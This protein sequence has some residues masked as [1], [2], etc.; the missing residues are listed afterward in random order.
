MALKS[1]GPRLAVVFSIAGWMAADA[2]AVQVTLNLVQSQS[3]VTLN[4][5]FGGSALVPQ[6]DPTVSTPGTTDGDPTQPSNRTPL[7][8]TIVV[9]VDNVMAPTTIQIL[10]ASID[11]TVTGNWL[12]EPQPPE[13]VTMPPTEPNPTTAAPADLGLKIMD[14]IPEL[15]CCNLHFAAIRD[16]TYNFATLDIEDLMQDPQ[17][18][19]PISE[20][21]NPQGE[22]SSYT[23]VLNQSGGF[24]DYWLGFPFS[25]RERDDLDDIRIPN[26]HTYDDT[27]N[28]PTLTPVP[29]APKSTY[30]VS[31]N[32]VTLTIPLD[33]NVIADF[34]QFVDGQ[35][36]ATFEIPSA[37]DGDHNGDGFVNA[38][39]YPAW[40][41]IP[42]MFGGDPAGYDAWRQQFGEAGAGGSGAVPEPAAAGFVVVGLVA[43]MLRR[44]HRGV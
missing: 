18:L 33:I 28:P 6:D 5:N 2:A 12:P 41:K 42:S 7:T 24:L 17:V 44:D 8:G 29:D 34:S 23:E 32:L 26:H 43:W 1:F 36:V 20:P 37:S 14:P 19:T 16:L 38:A 11:A 4:G 39:D 31:G 10:S 30:V 13:G 15:D 40:R 35:F 3:H 21:V 22:F 27:Q 25:E 9:D